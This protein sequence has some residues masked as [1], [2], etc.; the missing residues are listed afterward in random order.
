MIKTILGT[1]HGVAVILFSALGFF[2]LM[3]IG[4]GVNVITNGGSSTK[5]V[6]AL[7]TLVVSG[8]VLFILDKVN[9]PYKKEY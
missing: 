5:L 8:V 3:L 9:N 7:I 2:A 4:E 6:V 1:A